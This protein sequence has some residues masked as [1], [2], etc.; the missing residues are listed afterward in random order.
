MTLRNASL[1]KARDGRGP[2]VKVSMPVH[3]GKANEGIN[4]ILDGRGLG[5]MSLMWDK[6]YLKQKHNEQL[7][8]NESQEHK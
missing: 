5:S 3:G 4:I 2:K 8:P 7:T 1:A 6:V